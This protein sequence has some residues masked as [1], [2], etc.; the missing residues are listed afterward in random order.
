LNGEGAGSLGLHPLRYSFG[1]HPLR[2]STINTLPW[3]GCASVSLSVIDIV[4][5]RE[6]YGSRLLQLQTPED[7]GYNRTSVGAYH[8]ALYQITSV[9]IPLSINLP[10]RRAQPAG[11][12]CW[13]AGCPRVCCTLLSRRR[14]PVTCWHAGRRRR[15]RQ[16][17]HPA[18]R[19]AHRLPHVRRSQSAHRA[20]GGFRPRL[21]RAESRPA[22]PARPGPAA[23]HQG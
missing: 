22:G 8:V 10:A 13:H 15:C 2:H 16:Q 6:D 4:A 12:T 18:P 7:Y 20:A 3:P 14:T 5:A 9:L 1:L 11:S 19:R 17:A 21:G 23:W